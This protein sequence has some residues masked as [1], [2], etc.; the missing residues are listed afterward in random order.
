MKINGT[1]LISNFKKNLIEDFY[2]QNIN[3]LSLTHA[4]FVKE[5]KK[6]KMILQRKD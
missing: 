3:V 2:Q 4:M 1:Y 6:V 5:S